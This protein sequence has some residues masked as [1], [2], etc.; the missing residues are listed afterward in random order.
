[1][2]SLV[3]LGNISLIDWTIA[4]KRANGIIAGTPARTGLTDER[5]SPRS[6]SLGKK[7]QVNLLRCTPTLSLVQL[8]AQLRTTLL[9]AGGAAPDTVANVETRL[10]A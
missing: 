2:D 5:I 9:F 8:A 4:W 6:T 3:G 7:S 1:M 10:S